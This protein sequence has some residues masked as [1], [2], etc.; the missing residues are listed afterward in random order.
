[1]KVKPIRSE[2]DHRDVRREIERHWSAKEGTPE[3][4]RLEIL[5]TFVDAYEESIFPLIC[6]TQL[7]PSGF[8]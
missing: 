6:R 3:D 5:L 8:G 7:T 1:M 2:K 4:D